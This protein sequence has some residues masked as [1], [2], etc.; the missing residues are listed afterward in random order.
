MGD[1]DGAQDNMKSLHAEKMIILI[2][3]QTALA[4]HLSREM[5][6]EQEVWNL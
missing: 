5:S 2:H 3:Q 4:V 1:E 6:N